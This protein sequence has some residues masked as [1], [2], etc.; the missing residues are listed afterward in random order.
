MEGGGEKE[1]EECWRVTGYLPGHVRPGNSLVARRASQNFV[2][3]WLSSGPPNLC[4]SAAVDQV[5]R[6]NLSSSYRNAIVSY[7]CPSRSRV[8]LLP[9]LCG[10]K[11]AVSILVLV[12]S[13]T[14]TIIIMIMIMIIMDGATH[15]PLPSEMQE[16]SRRK[17]RSFLVAN[18]R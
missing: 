13:T 18:L 2:T 11:E 4:T 3:C 7:V 15:H 12:A 9:D 5:G 17:G 1:E 6:H 8:Y 14:T 16:G 10:L